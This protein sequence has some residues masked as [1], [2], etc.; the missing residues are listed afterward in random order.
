MTDPVPE[1][2]AR[3]PFAF[4]FGEEGPNLPAAV[5]QAL[6]AASVCWENPGGAGIFDSTRAKEIGDVLLDCVRANTIPRIATSSKH[7]PDAYL[8]KETR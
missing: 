8:V 5:F 1:P 6:G 7:N 4:D 3:E 2:A